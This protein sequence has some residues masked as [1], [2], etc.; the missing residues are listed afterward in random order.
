MSKVNRNRKKKR[1]WL[2]VTGVVALVFLIGACAYLFSIYTDVSRA[3]ETMHEPIDRKNSHKQKPEFA[4]AE[5]IKEVKNKS[6]EPFSVLLLG[7]DARPGDKG[8]SDTMIVMTV[9][10]EQDSTK[11]VSI[12]R[13][14][15]TMIVGKGFE[16]KI[17][18]AYAFG[19][20]TM[21]VETVE[22]FLDIPIDYY[23]QVNMEGFKDIVNAVGGVTVTNDL[24]FT[25]GGHDFNQGKIDLNG[26]E[27]LAYV[28][29][30]KEDPNGDFGRQKRQRQVIQGVINEGRSLSSITKL[31]EILDALSNNVKTN[32]TLREMADFQK[33]YRS[34]SKDLQQIQ[35]QGAGTTIDK[36]YYQVFS[37]EEI[38]AVQNE[39]KTHLEHS[40][41]TPAS[42]PN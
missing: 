8:R 30:R 37:E 40:E 13:D 1:T 18:H 15:R 9:N 27:A 5:E 12:P 29:M 10:P 26:E 33:N 39:L 38:L 16:D 4:S 6:R 17:N 42:T 19:G 25:E 11:M 21:A 35:L 20:P 14:A 2:R 24:T 3:V 32:M 41:S 36:I 22:N 31:D 28:R 34:A 23:V 7:V